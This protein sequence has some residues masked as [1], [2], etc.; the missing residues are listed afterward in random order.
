[1]KEG[2]FWKLML[3]LL[4]LSSGWELYFT[5]TQPE[6]LQ[7]THPIIIS[8]ITFILNLLTIFACLGLVIKKYILKHQFWLTIIF[9][10]IINTGLIFYFDF[11]SGGYTTSEFLI[12]ANIGLFVTLFFISPLIRYHY[13]IRNN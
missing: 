4:I 7:P 13:L 11:I 5:F 2:N 8:V 12:Y 10:Q 3:V 9:L 1:M 6:I